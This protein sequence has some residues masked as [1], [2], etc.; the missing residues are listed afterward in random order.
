MAFRCG[1]LLRSAS[2]DVPASDDVIAC[3]GADPIKLSVFREARRSLAA[4]IAAGVV[5]PLSGGYRR[6]LRRLMKGPA[7][8]NWGL[9]IA[10]GNGDWMNGWDNAAGRNPPLATENL[11]E[12]TGG[13]DSEH[14]SSVLSGRQPATSF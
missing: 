11:L 7:E 8:H 2:A 6:Y 4:A 14:P 1:G 3:E 10:H 12:N 5:D 9:S 13:A